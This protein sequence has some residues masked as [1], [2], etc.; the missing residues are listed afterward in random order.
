MRRPAVAFCWNVERVRLVLA[1]LGRIALGTPD[2]PAGRF[3]SIRPAWLHKVSLLAALA[4]SLCCCSASHVIDLYTADYRDTAATAG[5]SQLLVNILR[6]KDD[7]P[8][9]FYDLS[10]IHGSI[11]LNAGTGAS[12]PFGLHNALDANTLTPTVSAASLPTFD[13]G[14]MDTQDFTKGILAPIDVNVINQ[15]FDQGVDPR[16]IMLLFF[17]SYTTLGDKYHP[18]QIYLNNMACDNSHPLKD[19]LC[20]NQ[21]Y[22]FLGKI[23]EIFRRERINV[24]A[25]GPRAQLQANVYVVLSP[26]GSA[27]TGAW[28]LG[29]LQD[30]RQI[31]TKKFKLEGNQL[32]SI[33]DPHLAI[34][35]YE[36]DRRLHAL[37]PSPIGDAACNQ[38]EVK[39]LHPPSINSGLS[40]RSTY[41]ILQFLGQVLRFQQEKGNDRCLTLT[42]QTE[43]ERR[44]DTGEVFFQVNS[45]V[46]TP[47]VGARYDDAWYT[48]NFRPCTKIRVEACDYS[49]QVLA[50]LELLLN[51]NKL[52]KDIVS[53]P[54][55]QVVP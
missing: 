3:A 55:V 14:T 4:L 51:A 45:S 24:T 35:Y 50:V 34:C 54:R 41:E 17:S 36:P 18:G 30:L 40:V 53:T 13:V 42:G 6:A 15:L 8:I 25:E 33:S 22:G 49:L 43:A 27:M 37:F 44:C 5:D 2:A 52:A 28:N 26:V 7:L 23:D 32:F 11:Q 21:V 16:I 38:H 48:I 46:G 31:D 12:I 10:I 9:H 1:A 47:V 20:Y 39:V 19:G 29:N